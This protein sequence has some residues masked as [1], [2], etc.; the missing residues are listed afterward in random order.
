LILPK[1]FLRVRKGIWPLKKPGFTLIFLGNQKLRN[2]PSC[3][4][5]WQMDVKPIDDNDDEQPEQYENYKMSHIVNVFK[6][7]SGCF[8][9][10]LCRQLF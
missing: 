2:R 4:L 3:A 7:N 9:N 5:A 8:S 1:K 6:K 10:M